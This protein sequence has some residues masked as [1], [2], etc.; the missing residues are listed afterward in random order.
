MISKPWRDFRRLAEDAALALLGM[1]LCGGRSRRSA[2]GAGRSAQ[3][4]QAVPMSVGT[5]DSDNSADDS[6]V[7]WV[8]L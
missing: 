7:R 5:S 3:N 8:R 2:C 4:R 1:R 6:G